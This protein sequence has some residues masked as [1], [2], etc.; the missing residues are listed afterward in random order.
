MEL[1]LPYIKVDGARLRYV[2]ID[3]N[4]LFKN[5]DR[6][7]VANSSVY[8]WCIPNIHKLGYSNYIGKGVYNERFDG[9]I[10]AN[11]RA[12]NHKNDALYDAIWQVLPA[13]CVCN[14]ITGVTNEEARALE[15]LLQYL[16]TRDTMQ[17][18]EYR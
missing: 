9:F 13:N 2:P 15:A 12:I 5:R 14:I 4:K 10:K 18:G 7:Q 8:N 17:V 11:S 16:D 3:L 6:G 1:V